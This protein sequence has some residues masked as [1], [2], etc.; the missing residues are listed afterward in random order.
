MAK[1]CVK[2]YPQIFNSLKY[3]ELFSSMKNNMYF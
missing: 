2:I 3:I 1:M